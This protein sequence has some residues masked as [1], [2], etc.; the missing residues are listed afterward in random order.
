MT[1]SR[2]KR[3]AKMTAAP[4]GA[5]VTPGSGADELRGCTSPLCVR[6]QNPKPWYGLPR[7]GIQISP[8]R[9]Q[10][11]PA[12]SVTAR[13]NAGQ[14]G[15]TAI[16]L[17]RAQRERENTERHPLTQGAAADSTVY[18]PAADICRVNSPS[19]RTH[20]K[21]KTRFA[22][23]N[24]IYSSAAPNGG[25]A[26]KALISVL[27]KIGSPLPLPE[28][29]KMPAHECLHVRGRAFFIAFHRDRCIC[30]KSISPLR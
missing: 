9:R 21:S 14:A 24:D 13:T 16:A 5:G 26:R 17:R 30:V 25:A 11:T 12:D 3:C 1:Q 19:A 10:P 18:H 15:E 20:P 29:P 8:P 22:L 27:S 7:S 2:R 4:A 23:T 6:T 28:Q